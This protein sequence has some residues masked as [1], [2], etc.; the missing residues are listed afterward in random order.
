MLGYYTAGDG[1]GG[2]YDWVGSS[3]ATDDGGAVI[4]PTAETGQ[5]RW[6]LQYQGQPV[7]PNQWGAKA[8]ATLVT[9]VSQGLTNARLCQ[10][11]A[12]T[13]N[14]NAFNKAVAFLGSN[15][16]G[17]LRVPAGVYRTGSSILLPGPT[18]ANQNDLLGLDIKI[19]GAGRTATEI[20]YDNTTTGQLQTYAI[21]AAGAPTNLKVPPESGTGFTDGARTFVTIQDLS[22]A[23]AYN[24]TSLTPSPILGGGIRLFDARKADIDRVH[25]YGFPQ[26]DGLTVLAGL[27][28]GG[29]WYTDVENSFFGWWDVTDNTFVQGV[30]DA[31]WLQ[32]GIVFIGNEDGN[33]KPDEGL[34]IGSTFYN[35]KS[36][37][38]AYTGYDHSSP[39]NPGVPDPSQS[40]VQAGAA[41]HTLIRDTMTSMQAQQIDSGTVFS[42]SSNTIVYTYNSMTSPSTLTG[43]NQ[44]TVTLTGGMGAG[45]IGVVT[46]YQY[47]T[48]VSGKATITIAGNWDVTPN[49][50]TTFNL[51]YRMD[52]VLWDGQ[53]SFNA[54]GVYMEDIVQPYHLTANGSSD[55]NLHGGEM[56][57]SNGDYVVSDAQLTGTA[58]TTMGTSTITLPSTMLPA[59]PS[60]LDSYYNGRLI[61][62]TN[63]TTTET[64][65]I[66]AYSGATKVATIAVNWTNSFASGSAFTILGGPWP[67]S[68]TGGQTRGLSDMRNG[69]SVFPAEWYA[70]AHVIQNNPVGIFQESTTDSLFID[71]IGAAGTTVKQGYVGRIGLAKSLKVNNNVNETLPI[72]VAGGSSTTLYYF[73]QMV[74]IARSG[75]EAMVAVD[76]TIAVGD[77]LVADFT[78]PVGN[79]GGWAIAGNT[80]TD[81]KLI[82]GYALGICSACTPAAP[83]FVLARIH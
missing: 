21:D 34:V 55:F 47:N 18:M 24:T 59:P 44:L 7:S 57:V 4:Q 38:V 3:G 27:L 54:F 71:Q 10:S 36:S 63:G 43:D 64:H 13:D 49:T 74:P 66:T 5:G 50:T 46:M 76:G 80:T 67:S 41:E 81:P 22:I 51:G 72:V 9:S 20:C 14:A 25:I 52:G 2:T 8:D 73:G 79:P 11:G 23:G 53:H 56:N 65:Q 45:Q 83:G 37:C 48:P 19:D 75:S 78:N 29:N 42:A 12:G 17:E 62:V 28:T 32:R 70:P 69:G 39:P 60:K 61:Q 15:G 6:I 26:G 16:G 31:S 30:S 35:C 40:G 68:I 77:T 33:S 82:I 1:G 58:S